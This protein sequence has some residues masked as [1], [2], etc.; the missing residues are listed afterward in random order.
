MDIDDSEQSTTQTSN[1]FPLP[2]NTSISDFAESCDYYPP[3]NLTPTPCWTDVITYDSSRQMTVIVPQR[4]TNYFLFIGQI[5]HE[6]KSPV[7]RASAADGPSQARS[8]IRPSEHAVKVYPI[9]LLNNANRLGTED[10][11]KEIKALQFLQGRHSNILSIVGSY[12][13]FTAGEWFL[14]MPLY[15]RGDGR[16]LMNYYRQEKKEDTLPLGLMKTAI[17]DLLTA[18]EYLHS[19]GITHHDISPDQLLFDEASNRFVLIDFGMCIRQGMNLK[20]GC[21]YSYPHAHYCGKNDYWA[22]EIEMRNDTPCANP[23]KRDIWSLGPTLVFL[24]TGENIR[25]IAQS[26]GLEYLSY[27]LFVSD[28][29]EQLLSPFEKGRGEDFA[30]AVDFIASVMKYD[31]AD[32]PTASQLLSH[33][34]LSYI[35]D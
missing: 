11:L 8:T 10:P 5:I 30:S 35:N 3:F 9:D 18:L 33:P 14:D 19:L 20:T 12:Q 1:N 2:A 4:N 24:L 16:Q 31:P 25:N 28:N 13:E 6:K 27:F 34:W 17:R 15:P 7:H 26:R 22:P 32:R 21:F 23:T 29:M